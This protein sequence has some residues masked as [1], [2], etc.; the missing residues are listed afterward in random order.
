MGTAGRNVARPSA[1]PSS[2]ALGVDDDEAT[3]DATLMDDLG[4]E[5]IDLLDILFRIERSDGRED[6]GGRPRRR[7]PG[8][9]LRRRVRR[10]ERH[11]TAK[12]LEQLKKV[13]PQID[14]DEYAGKLQADEVIMHF[15]V[16]NLADMVAERGGSAGKRRNRSRD[17]R[18]RRRRGARR[19]PRRG[20]RA[21]ARCA[22]HGRRARRPRRQAAPSR[23]SRG[24]LR[25]EGGR[26]EGARD[27][28]R[29]P[30]AVD[31]RRGR[32]RPERPAARAPRRRGR[33][34]RRA[35]AAARDRDLARPFGRHRD[36]AGA[37]GLGRGGGGGVRF[38]LI[39]RVDE[40]EPE[41]SVRGRKVTSLFEEIWDESPDGP[42]M[43]PPLVLEA[44]CQAGTWLV[45]ISTDRR[46]RAALLSIGS[47][48][49]LGDVRP[50]DVVELEATVES[51]SDEVAVISGPRRRGR[52][53][54]ARGA[55]IMCA[56]IDADTLADSTTRSGCR[57]CSRGR[58]MTR[59]VAVTGTRRRHARR[60]RR[61]VD[62]AV[63]GRRPQRASAGSRRS[64]PRRSRRR[65][66]AW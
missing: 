44:L 36:R 26:P 59:R 45:M 57:R 2:A 28:P 30:D 64:T 56:L 34:A 62:L 38:H 47:V 46:K 63:A 5:S 10:R 27:G 16:Q 15:T 54:R 42:V 3:P 61:R 4:A 66:P 23:A 60:Q 52:T 48:E 65:S 19:A 21:R 1:R 41:R 12:G 17:R 22:L 49:F 9:D 7:D 18:R 31:G 11:V 32:E 43:P 40:W 29:A 35:A 50:G 6:P 13:M 39:D 53:R 20:A 58:G 24:A 55:Q 8:R 37:R 33:G 51:F 25:G 14:A